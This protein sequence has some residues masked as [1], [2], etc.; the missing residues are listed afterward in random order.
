MIQY[1]GLGPV[2][3]LVHGAHA[4]RAARLPQRSAVRA[5]AVGHHGDPAVVVAVPGA[6]G[7][8]S[9]A[10]EHKTAP[11]RRSRPARPIEP[12]VVELRAI[13][14]RA[15]GLRAAVMLAVVGIAAPA[16][17]DDPPVPAAPS[18]PSP[19]PASPAPPPSATSPAPAAPST[20]PAP[21]APPTSPAPGT[22]PSAPS[23]AP[24]PPPSA[25]PAA[26]SPAPPA[27]AA[28][29][30]AA[31]AGKPATGDDD[32]EPRLSLPTQADRD[33][34][35]E[36]RLPARPRPGLRPARRPGRRAERP[37][38]RPDGP[39][40]AAARR[41]A[42]RSWRR[43]ST[44]R[45]RSPAGCRGCGSPARSIRPGTSRRA[46]ASRSASGSAASSR[47]APAG[48]TPIRCPAR[49][50]RRTRSPTRATRSRAAAASASP[51]WC[52][53]SGPTCS[54]RATQTSV[55]LEVVGQWTGCVDDT[56]R[57]EPDTGTAIVRRQWWPH[58]GATLGWGIAWR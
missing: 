3:R 17:A 18:S 54:G 27:A 42:G 6:G 33:R 44:P 4:L 26:A 38:D 19:N 55:A 32:G 21:A 34:V 14:L 31:E 43:S 2:R 11:R 28:G 13:G 51:A 29:P 56:D 48:W 47:A 1:V 53:P 7:A 9:S 49:S 40:R 58:A 23:S 57:V 46:S 20:S 15:I 35:A 25:S 36:Q 24:A 22:P 39:G 12:C 52:A 5:T 8:V 50:T 41:R 10:C 45:R 16:R 30:P 37:A